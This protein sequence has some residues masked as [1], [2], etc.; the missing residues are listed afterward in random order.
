M[1][2]NVETEW[3]KWI[4]KK[5]NFYT[6][7]AADLYLFPTVEYKERFFNWE[8]KTKREEMNKAEF[9]RGCT[10]NFSSFFSVYTIYLIWLK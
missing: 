3:K 5:S 2:P 8:N 10:M 7:P 6:V 9:R 1:T 4:Y